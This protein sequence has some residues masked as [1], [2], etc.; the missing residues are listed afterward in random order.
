MAGRSDL[1]QRLGQMTLGGLAGGE[2][3]AQGGAEVAELGDAG[4][5]AGLFGER[6]QWYWHPAEIAN[7]NSGQCNP[8]GFCSHP[9][10]TMRRIYN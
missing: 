2:A 3:L 6:W 4:D 9:S 10:L 7:I 5:D 8:L 1:D